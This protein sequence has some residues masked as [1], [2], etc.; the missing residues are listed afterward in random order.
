[1]YGYSR[2]QAIGKKSH[3]LLQTILPEPI[4]TIQNHL[5]EKGEWR[6][7][8]KQKKANGS[9]VTVDSHWILHYDDSKP[10]TILEVN[11]DVTQQRENERMAL[12]GQ[13]AA[14]VGHDIRNP[15]Q[16][17]TSE[18]YLAKMDVD[19]LEQGEAKENLQESLGSI[20]KQVEYI[21]KIVLDLQDFHPRSQSC[22]LFSTDLKAIV[23]GVV[24]DQEV[25]EEV[26]V[27]WKVEKEVEKVSYGSGDC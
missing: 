17:I 13:T 22:I 11:I 24:R 8:L 16:A 23:E 12:V 18:L 7:E 1:M 26:E 2:E 5:C 25:P 27:D 10:A 9:E 19:F 20:N 3:F 15:L 14:M 6:G 21:N 4:E